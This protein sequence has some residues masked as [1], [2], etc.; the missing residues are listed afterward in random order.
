MWITWPNVYNNNK[1]DNRA[2]KFLNIQL[3]V[4]SC[5]RSARVR[6]LN[7]GNDTT[8]NM[9]MNQTNYIC[10]EYKG[11]GWKLKVIICIFDALSFDRLWVNSRGVAAQCTYVGNLAS[12]S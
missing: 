12:T 11:L 3:P 10:S 9:L 6:V 8:P 7:D 5:S 2:Y 4:N 1:K